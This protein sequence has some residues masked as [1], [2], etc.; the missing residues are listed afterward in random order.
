MDRHVARC[1]ADRLVFLRGTPGCVWRRALVHAQPVHVV[2][3]ARSGRHRLARVVASDSPVTLVMSEIDRQ[4]AI[5]DRPWDLCPLSQDGKSTVYDEYM[6]NTVGSQ[7]ATASQAAG[8]A[9]G[10]RF[11]PWPLR[12]DGRWR[13][14]TAGLATRRGFR[15]PISSS[16]TG[17]VRISRCSNKG[18]GST[19][20]SGR[21]DLNTTRGT[22]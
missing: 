9:K 1:C 11:W 10:G 5:T 16:C 15:R 14:K 3:M 8:N 2:H 4:E 6:L 20:S 13:M 12:D 18:S 21:S 7:Q 17:A 19:R 22:S